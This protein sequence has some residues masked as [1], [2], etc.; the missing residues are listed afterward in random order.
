MYQIITSAVVDAPV[1]GYV[2]RL[3]HNNKPLYVPQNGH[4][5]NNMPSDTKEDMME[6]FAQDV[7]AR[8]R[9]LKRLMGRRNYVACV[10]YD[11][12]VISGGQ[13]TGKMSIAVDFLVQNE[14]LGANVKYG[15]VIIPN[16][17][18]GR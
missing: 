3:L 17:E 5:A 6:I 12:D 4:R 10:A 13:P 14:T 8:P 1:G 2:L 15:P 11:P 16:L 9:E 18:Y 7:D